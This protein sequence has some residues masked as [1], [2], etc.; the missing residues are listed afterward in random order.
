MLSRIWQRCLKRVEL[1]DMQN[2]IEGSAENITWDLDMLD[3]VSKV[4]VERLRCE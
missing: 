3:G 4:E 2:D 1:A